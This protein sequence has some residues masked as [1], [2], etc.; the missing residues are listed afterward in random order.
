MTVT[1]ATTAELASASY[2]PPYKYVT[3]YAATPLV[4]GTLTSESTAHVTGMSSFPKI[5]LWLCS[6]R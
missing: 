5:V 3:S 6:S 1:G 2:T 4:T